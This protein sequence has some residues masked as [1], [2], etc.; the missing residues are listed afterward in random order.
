MPISEKPGGQGAPGFFCMLGHKILE[1]GLVISACESFGSDELI[2]LAAGVLVLLVVDKGDASSHPRSEVLAGG[3]K[4]DDRS[5]R[6]VFTAMVT[7]A[8][9]YGSSS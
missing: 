4:D 2:V 5:A 3:T 9:D 6:H 8:L 7:N 1:D